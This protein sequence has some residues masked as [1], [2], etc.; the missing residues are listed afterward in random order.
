MMIRSLKVKLNL[1]FVVIV[2]LVLTLSGGYGYFQQ[3]GQLTATYQR[4]IDNALD[5]MEAS[6]SEPL[7]NF[8]EGVVKQI[9]QSEL[10]DNGIHAILVFSSEEILIA[11]FSKG[12]EQQLVELEAPPSSESEKIHRPL[13]YGDGDSRKVIGQVELYPDHTEMEQTLRELVIFS[14]LEI[15]LLDLVI[16][17][18]LSW[19]LSRFVL[20][21]IRKVADGI[22]GVA[23]GDGDLTQRLAAESQDELGDL[24]DWFDAVMDKL[25]MAML[26]LSENAGRLTETAK[27]ATTL[28]ERTTEGVEEQRGKSEMVATAVNQVSATVHEIAKNATEASDAADEAQD[29]VGNG[30]QVVNQTI[31]SINNLS[32]EIDET[33]RVIQ[34]VAEESNKITSILSVIRAI[35]DQTNLLALNAAIES[36]RAGEMGRGFAVVADEVRT[37][38]QRTQQSTEEIQSMIE[39]LEAGIGEAVEVTVKGRQLTDEVIGKA[40]KAGESLQDINGSVSLIT[41]L[42]AQIA[43]AT[44]EQSAVTNEVAE[45]VTDIR[46]IAESTA[47]GISESQ[48]G[49][50]ELYTLAKNLEDVVK[51]FST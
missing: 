36:A 34:R 24:S 50:D 31:E 17:V 4:Q 20:E 39:S 11:G 38:A 46:D 35:A 30:L 9:V 8:D 48:L 23:E 2:T 44:E 18:A 12:D 37:L 43:T 42:A 6:L 47:L 16:L 22:R 40:N 32:M 10:A 29:N 45:N 33:G 49:K 28:I 13:H 1:S 27:Q 25:Q 7:W 19:L 41:G 3:Q 15:V 51:K 14:L 5:R 26:D 21:P